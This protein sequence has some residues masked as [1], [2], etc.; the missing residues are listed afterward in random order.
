MN[1]AIVF[2]VCIIVG[3]T[4]FVII[5]LVYIILRR[6]AEVKKGQRRRSERENPT[7][8]LTGSDSESDSYTQGALDKDEEAVSTSPHPTRT[9]TQE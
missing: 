2:L 6:R 4:A 7:T 3:L 1:S 5:A 9:S 8:A